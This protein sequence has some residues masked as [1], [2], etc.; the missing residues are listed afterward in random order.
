[1]TSS[2]Y[3]GQS[4][5]IHGGDTIAVTSDKMVIKW[6]EHVYKSNRLPIIRTGSIFSLLY[7]TGGHTLNVSRLT[8][9]EVWQQIRQWSHYDEIMYVGEFIL[10]YD[11]RKP[12]KLADPPISLDVNREVLKKVALLLSMKCDVLSTLARRLLTKS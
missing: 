6:L 7:Y 10:F 11:D 5:C 2:Y 3:D 12:L 8:T 1:M 9:S 4:I